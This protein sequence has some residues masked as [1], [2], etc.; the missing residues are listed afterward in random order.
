MK[1]YVV[2]T[3]RAAVLCW[4]YK[5]EPKASDCMIEYNTDGNIVKYLWYEYM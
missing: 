1:F 5:H 2:Y 3:I 4:I